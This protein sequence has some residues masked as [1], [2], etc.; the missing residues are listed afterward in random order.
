MRRTSQRGNTLVE[1]TLIGIPVV[2]ILLSIFEMS[3]MMWTYHTLAHAVKEGVRYAVVHGDLRGKA[4]LPSPAPPCVSTVASVATAIRDSGVGLIPNQLRLSMRSGATVIATN[5]VPQLIST[6]GATVFPPA[7]F[8]GEQGVDVTVTA[9]YNF[10]SVI[11]LFW[12]GAGPYIQYGN[13]TLPA[14]STERIEF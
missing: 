8:D 2:F 12:P 6:G 3:R 1:F 11:A 9:T 13:V 4:C 10:F 5:S 7:G 14:S